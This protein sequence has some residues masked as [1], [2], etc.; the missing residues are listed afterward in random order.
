MFGCFLDIPNCWLL[1]SVNG[2]RSLAGPGLTPGRERR[3]LGPGTET[4]LG[5][6]LSQ[7]VRAVM[8]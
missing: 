7:E 8:C 5:M 1:I 4:V 6:A 3:D 2:F